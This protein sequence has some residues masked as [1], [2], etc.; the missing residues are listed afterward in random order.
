M[1]YHILIGICRDVEFIE[2]PL[3]GHGIPAP[4]GDL[5]L[6][7]ELVSPDTGSLPAQGEISG[8]SRQVFVTMVPVSRCVRVMNRFDNS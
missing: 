1:K 7:T 8:D 2:Y 5:I 4:A 3:P 6:A